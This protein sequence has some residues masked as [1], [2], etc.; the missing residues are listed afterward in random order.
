MKHIII[1]AAII[2]TI[3]CAQEKEAQLGPEDTLKTFYTNLCQG[4][5]EGAASLCDTLNM[6]EYITSVQQIWAKNSDSVKTILPAIMSET[7]T[8]ITEVVKNGQDR[9]IFYKL[10]ATDGQNKEKIAILRKEEG[11]WRITAITDKN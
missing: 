9:T 7:E 8:E 2:L 5:F 6:K 1:L 10:K 4:E 3:G 11:A